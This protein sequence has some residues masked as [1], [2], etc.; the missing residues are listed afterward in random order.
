MTKLSVVKLQTG[1][2]SD[3][4]TCLRTLAEEIERGDYGEVCNVA[5]VVDAN[6]EQVE[7]GL[8]GHA[9]SPDAVCAFLLDVGKH[10][11]IERMGK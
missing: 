4:P 8:L 7:V 3:I 11:L 1:D 6:Y 2:I 9:G 5:W 10:S